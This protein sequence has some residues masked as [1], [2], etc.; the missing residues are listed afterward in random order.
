MRCREAV[1]VA[2]AAAQRWPCRLPASVPIRGALRL[3]VS[4]GVQPAC[5]RGVCRR[6]HPALPHGRGPASVGRPADSLHK[7]VPLGRLTAATVHN[8]H[9][10]TCQTNL[11]EKRTYIV[12]LYNWLQKYY[13]FHIPFHSYKITI[14]WK[15]M[16]HYNAYSGLLNFFICISNLWKPLPPPIY[17]AVLTFGRC[18][19]LRVRSY[20]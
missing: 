20:T 3:P 10:S 7:C 14:I 5:Q 13:H 9:W 1:R 6:V 18:L 17:F 8:S 16:L 11:Q 15:N 4:G 12:C 2:S 19:H